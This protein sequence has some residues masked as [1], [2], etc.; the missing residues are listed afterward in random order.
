MGV[1]GHG[2]GRKLLISSM[3]LRDRV[4][5]VPIGRRRGSLVRFIISGPDCAKSLARLDSPTV[6]GPEEKGRR[7]LTLVM[8]R[9]EGRIERRNP[10]AISPLFSGYLGAHC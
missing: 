9:S 6:E 7:K 2:S 5:F 3:S 4:T 8:R 1:A 10:P